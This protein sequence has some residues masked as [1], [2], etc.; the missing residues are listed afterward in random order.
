MIGDDRASKVSDDGQPKNIL[1][2]WLLLLL[3]E[4]PAHGYDLVERLEGVG[5]GRDAGSLYRAL[6]GLEHEGLVRSAWEA[7]LIGP[8]RRCYVVTDEGRE[9]LR[10]WVG[11]LETVQSSVAAFLDRCRSAVDEDRDRV[12]PR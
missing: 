2:A 10:A 5:V 4:S 11:I 3:N 8:D 7:S 6:R 1:R 9:R 12:L